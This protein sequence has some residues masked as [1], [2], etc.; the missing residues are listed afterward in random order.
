M[1]AFYVF[2]MGLSLFPIAITLS[3]HHY[4]GVFSI[5]RA[6]SDGYHGYTKTKRK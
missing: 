6:S 2:D 4:S 1:G 3:V 5:D